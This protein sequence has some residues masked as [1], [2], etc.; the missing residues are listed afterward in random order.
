[1]YTRPYPTDVLYKAVHKHMTPTGAKKADAAHD[2]LVY[3]ED[4][5]GGGQFYCAFTAG[6]APR[7]RRARLR[8]VAASSSAAASSASSA[9]SPSASSFSSSSSSSVLLLLRPRAVPVSV[10]HFK[11]NPSRHRCGVFR[12]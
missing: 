1:M 11:R 2:P 7:R 6:P 5:P 4:L 8:A 12:P 9:Y 3:D 10:P